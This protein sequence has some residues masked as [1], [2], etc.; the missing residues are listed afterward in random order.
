MRLLFAFAALMMI[1]SPVYAGESI[2]FVISGHR[3]HVEAPRNCNSVSCVSVS[4]PGIYQTLRKLDRDDD[5]ASAA[6]AA[7]VKPV[8]ESPQPASPTPI[9]APA[10]PEVAPVACAPSVPPQAPAPSL[11]AKVEPAP[12]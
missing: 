7:P 5:A 12:P 8:A 11:P 9:V 1:G 4:I 2:S 6:D 3:V 10:K